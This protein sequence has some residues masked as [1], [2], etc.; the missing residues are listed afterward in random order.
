MVTSLEYHNIYPLSMS[1]RTAW[2][3]L[4]QALEILHG[5]KSFIF[6]K[7]GNDCF[8]FLTIPSLNTY[9]TLFFHFGF[10]PSVLNWRNHLHYRGACES[11]LFPLNLVFC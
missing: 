6:Y 9:F 11:F 1:V 7:R 4:N 2:N 3:Q 8:I 10:P 5:V